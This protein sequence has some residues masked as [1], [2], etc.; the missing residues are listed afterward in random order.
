MARSRR[1][2]GMANTCWISA[3]GAAVRARRRSRRRSGSRP[4]GRCGCCRYVPGAVLQML[5]ESADE[6]PGVE[7][8][9]ARAVPAV[10]QSAARCPKLQQQFERVAVG[11]DRVGA[12]L[13]L[14]H[15]LV[16][17]EPLQQR[18]KVVVARRS[19][20]THRLRRTC[21]RVERRPGQAAAVFRSDTSTSTS[22]RRDRGTWLSPSASGRSRRHRRDTT[23]ATS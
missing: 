6:R 7:V 23:P 14:S 21:D 17:E 8:G 13:T 18:R 16:G 5:Q 22:G 10:V 15:Q 20:V 19:R 12:G 2:D 1:C 11:G 4:T 3:P 9:E